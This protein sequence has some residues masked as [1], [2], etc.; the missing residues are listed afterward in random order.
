VPAP[1]I[2]KPAESLDLLYLAW[3][4]AVR[5]RRWCPAAAAITLYIDSEQQP[6]PQSCLRLSAQ[7]DA[8]GM[9]KDVVDWRWGEPERHA[10][11][12]YRQLFDRQWQAWNSGPIHWH[13][14]FEPGTGWQI[15][16]SDFYHLMGGTRMDASP[17]QGVVDR[18]LRVHDIPNQF[19]ASLHGIPHR[20]Q[21]QPH[22]DAA[23]PAVG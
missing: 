17:Q 13:H 22:A 23:H 2:E 4:A 15:D 10:F 1:Y 14:S 21:P 16:A 7:R 18:K 12:C 6:N 3:K 5:R 19:L 20:Q 11:T 8:L 9:P